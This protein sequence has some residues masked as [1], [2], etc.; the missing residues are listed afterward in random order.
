MSDETNTSTAAL[1]TSPA[2]KPLPAFLRH[3]W[4]P[5]RECDGS[6]HRENA[7]NCERCNGAGGAATGRLEMVLHATWLQDWSRCQ[8]RFGYSY[9]AGIEPTT[10]KVELNFGKAVHA[11]QALRFETER[12]AKGAADMAILEPL[13]RTLLTTHFDAHPQPAD[14]YR[15]A[16]RA[17]E[18]VRAF[19]ATHPAFD[20]EVLG[21]E[22]RFEVEVGTV[23]LM[24]VTEKLVGSETA[25]RTAIPVY[26][27]GTKDLIVAWHNGIWIVDWKTTKDW[28][29]DLSKNRNLLEGRRSFQFR[30]YAWAEREAQRVRIAKLSEEH[31]GFCKGCGNTID[32]DV[33]HCG[34][35]ISL[36]GYSSGHSPVPMGCTCGYADQSQFPKPDQRLVRPILGTCG[37]W[38]VCRPP[39]V[40]P[41]AK[42]T[43]REHFHCEPFAF[44][45][46]ELEEWRASFLDKAAAILRAWSTRNYDM[47][48]GLA[49]GGIGRCPFYDICE[50][51]PEQRQ[52]LIDNGT[53][54]QARTRVEDAASEE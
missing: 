52:T 8:T 47:A 27:A 14:E 16:G 53:D 34:D 13:Q 26:F 9:D 3:R 54:F 43:P 41:P 12:D 4:E 17:I 18:L 1:A 15:N 6:G 50:T 33:C 36:H 22:E 2:T 32:P 49:C 38:L 40:R 48:W 51:A 11:A 20:W 28:N 24:T 45:D 7:S 23:D 5:C 35:L 42:P 19:N 44:K 31:G 39:Y 46:H 37:F 10:P 30:G 29:D 25:T 21:V